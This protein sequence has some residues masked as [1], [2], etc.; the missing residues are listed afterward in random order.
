M[1]KLTTDEF[2]E[3]SKLIWGDRFDY[4]L[5]EYK[6]VKTKVKIICHI[7]GIFEQSPQR[8]LEGRET[9]NKKI[10]Y[11][12]KFI[13]RANEKFNFKFD[14]SLV[15]YKNNDGKVII[16]CPIHGQF[17]QCT[18]DHLNSKYACN[19][20][21]KDV[22]VSNKVVK[23]KVIKIK[24]DKIKIDR[25]ELF[26]K[27]CFEIHGDRY[28]YSLTEFKS[29]NDKVKIICREHG[30]FEQ[31]ASAHTSDQG[32]MECRLEKRRTG[33][34]VFISRCF[35]IH[36]DKYDY[37]LITEYVNSKTKVDII[38]K[39]HGVFEVTPDN[40]TNSK[41]GCPECKKLGLEKFIEKSNIKHHDKYDYSLIKEY[42]N[43]K[44][45][46]DIICKEHGIFSQRMTDHM[47]GIGCP[48]CTQVRFR[49]STEDF[50]KRS[51]EIH[52][53][54]YL[55]SDNIS[56]KSNKDKVEINCR[57]HGIFLQ[58]VNSHLS[59]AGCLSCKES[60][61][62]SEV[63]NYLFIN[64]IEFIQQKKFSDCVYHSGLSFDFYLPEYNICI[65]YNGIQHYKPIEYF[66]GS[67]KFNYQLIRD[68]IKNDY[69]LKNNIHLI[70]IK[71]NESV[72]DKLSIFLDNHRYLKQD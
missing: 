71:Y 8:H 65:E 14:Y 58:Q 61:G 11:K 19:D 9:L 18:D 26:F 57:E 66:G 54:K 45:K 62:E 46:V 43:N 44:K 55:Y 50:I 3:K 56:F 32:C 36:G 12:Q 38:C 6:G 60:K 5:V 31:R 13:E 30:I 16:I 39:K 21:K 68:K 10:E 63:R 59:G 47:I 70:I 22:S 20:C 35:E 52:N 40:H 28:D 53:N 33:L 25:K 1:K 37:S 29:S 4:S 15:E 17:E 2:I 27:R 24:L 72:E 64:A 41:N 69:C 67:E 49:T 34:D 42:V 7:N 23:E 48:E 51:K